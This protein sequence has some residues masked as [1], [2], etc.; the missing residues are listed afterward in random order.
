MPELAHVPLCFGSGSLS[1]RPPSV[2]H[3]V[4]DVRR[5]QKLA[6]EFPSVV[7][8]RKRSAKLK[9]VPSMLIR[10]GHRYMHEPYPL[11]RHAD[12]ISYI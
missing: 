4:L 3:K 2:A 9:V 5:L 11:P 10:V 8:V 1:V 12:I 6:C 7:F